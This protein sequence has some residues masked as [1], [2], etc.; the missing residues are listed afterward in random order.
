MDNVLVFPWYYLRVVVYLRCLPSTRWISSITFLNLQIL[1]LEMD[2]TV[3]FTTHTHTPVIGYLFFIACFAS[4]SNGLSKLELP[5]LALCISQFDNADGLDRFFQS[6]AIQTI[7]LVEVIAPHRFP[8]PEFQRQRVHIFGGGAV[9]MEHWILG[10]FV[11]WN[12]LSD[13]PRDLADYLAGNVL[14]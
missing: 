4:T 13:V 6:P 9:R 1:R 7:P 12:R 2:W 10:E 11:G 14:L 8:G 5:P 3:I